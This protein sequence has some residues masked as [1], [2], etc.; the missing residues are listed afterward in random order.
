MSTGLGI[1]LMVVGAILLFALTAGSPHWLNLQIVGIILILTG[2]LG[3]A[4]PRLARASRYQDRLGR[5]VRPGQ[6]QPLGEPWAD[7][8]QGAEDDGPELVRN[9]SSLDGPTLADDILGHEHDPP[10]PP[11]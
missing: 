8:N 7:D 3:L 4:L 10:L 11:P 2:A 6:Y 1:C 5:W 9:V